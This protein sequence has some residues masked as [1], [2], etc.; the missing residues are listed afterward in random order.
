MIQKVI[1]V[2][3]KRK[4]QFGGTTYDY[5]LA[6]NTPAPKKGDIIRM[7]TEDKKQTVCNGTRVQ[8]VDVKETSD[9]LQPQV[10][11]YVRSSMEEPSLSLVKF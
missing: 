11:S 8:V 3:F 4:G 10:I 2:Q 7:L 1:S 6:A 9:Y 5:L